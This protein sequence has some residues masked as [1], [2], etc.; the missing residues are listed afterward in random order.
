M[1]RRK[2]QPPI[3]TPANDAGQSVA[4][5][6]GGDAFPE[7][8]APAELAHAVVTPERV[9]NADRLARQ[10]L[11]F[12][13]A[14]PPRAAPQRARRVSAEVVK[15]ETALLSLG[16]R[17]KESLGHAETVWAGKRVALIKSFPADVLAAL[18]AMGVL[19]FGDD[20]QEVEAVGE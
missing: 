12:G 16:R 17:R 13:D 18:E 8:F 9:N 20:G 14:A 1:T 15:A 19:A 11:A 10:G 4:F 3:T 5:P 6:E 2:A 7:A